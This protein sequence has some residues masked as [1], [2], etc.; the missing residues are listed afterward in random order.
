MLLIVVFGRTHAACACTSV[1]SAGASYTRGESFDTLRLCFEVGEMESPWLCSLL[2][3]ITALALVHA[4]A[5]GIRERFIP[6]GEL[7]TQ[8]DLFDHLS[9]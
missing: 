1:L 2:A 9:C 6:T 3:A 8:H 7:V 5:N 4:S